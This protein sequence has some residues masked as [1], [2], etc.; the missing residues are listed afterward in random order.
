MSLALMLAF[1]QLAHLSTVLEKF[2]GAG[3][4]EVKGMQSPLRCICER[5]FEHHV[6]ANFSIVAD[7]VHEATTRYLGWD[8]HRHQN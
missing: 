1:A 5:G 4:V 6:A 3:V 2:G 7:A 8:M